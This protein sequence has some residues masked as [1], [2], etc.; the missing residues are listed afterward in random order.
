MFVFGGVGSFGVGGGAGVGVAL[1]ADLVGGVV[2]GA[3]RVLGVIG[4]SVLRDFAGVE[5]FCGAIFVGF[6]A[7][8]AGIGFDAIFVP[9]V[10]FWGVAVMVGDFEVVVFAAAGFAAAGFA[11]VVF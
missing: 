6:F 9:A 4:F 2:F 10:D 7:G 3:E 1:M 5:V 11:D 8:A